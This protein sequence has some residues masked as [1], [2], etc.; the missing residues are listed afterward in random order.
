M[1][2]SFIRSA[3]TRLSGLGVA[4][5]ALSEEQRKL[6]ARNKEKAEQARQRYAERAKQARQRAMAE[7]CY[8]EQLVRAQKSAERMKADREFHAARFADKMWCYNVPNTRLGRWLLKVY[9]PLATSTG[10]LIWRELWCGR[11]Y[12][13]AYYAEFE[14]N[15]KNAWA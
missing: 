2:Q 10:M 8:K 9:H 4:S 5:Q 14:L 11:H 3:Y 12:N 13:R 6:T 1:Q 7:K 15:H